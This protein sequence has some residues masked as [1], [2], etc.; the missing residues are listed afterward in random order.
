MVG[1]FQEIVYNSIID[2]SSNL[3]ANDSSI[4]L[5]KNNVNRQIVEEWEK[6]K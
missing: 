1:K 5:S 4:F 3:N 6:V 2:K